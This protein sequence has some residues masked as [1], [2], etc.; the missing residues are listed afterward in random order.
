MDGSIYLD[1]VEKFASPKL[2]GKDVQIFW[3]R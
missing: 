2:E 3:A 1:M